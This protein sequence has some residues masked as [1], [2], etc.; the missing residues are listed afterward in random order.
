MAVVAVCIAYG[1]M[2]KPMLLTKPIILLLLDY[3]PFDRFKKQ[4]FWKLILEKI[5]F[6][7]LS[8]GSCA[9]TLIAQQVAIGS[10]ESLP[11]ASRIDNAL[12]TYVNYLRHMF[13][14]AVWGRIVV[15][16]SGGV[17]SGW[18]VAASLY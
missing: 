17:A 18:L 4:R 5:P 6:V 10:T 7:I 12:V 8:V 9:A 13:G 16:Q 14:R 2:S 11:L 15:V 3:W 1:F